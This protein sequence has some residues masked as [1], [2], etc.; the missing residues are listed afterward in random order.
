MKHFAHSCKT[1]LLLAA[2]ALFVACA[3]AT[4]APAQ[5]ANE[6][7]ELMNRIHQLEN[8]VQTVSR[9][10]FRGERRGGA[11]P[12]NEETAGDDVSASPAAGFEVRMTQIEDQQR[13]LTGQFEKINFDLQQLKSRLDRLQAD[14]EQR[15]QQGGNAAPAAISPVESQGAPASGGTLGTLTTGAGGNGPAE[16]LYEEAFASIRETK[17]DQAESG[18]KDFLSRYPDHPLAANAQYWLGETYYVRG[19]YKQSAKMFAQG[20][21]NFPKSAKATDSLL[22]LGLSL[23]KLGKK[24]DACLSLRQLQKEIAD[25]ANPLRRR[26]VQEIK[27]LGCS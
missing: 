20:Y 4:A 8:Q 25:E 24:D 3:A 21:Q 6:T 7:S 19:D 11:I 10:V 18:F 27:Q 9:A 13:A 5:T 1:R 17:Y 14:T 22:K 2:G 15:F 16:A 23:S 26:A 12:E